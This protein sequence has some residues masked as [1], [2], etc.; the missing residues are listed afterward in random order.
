MAKKFKLVSHV[1]E[2]DIQAV[3]LDYLASL[4]GAKFWTNKTTGT[5]DPKFGG[6][7]KLNGRHNA[8]GSPD[9][10]GTIDGKFIGI[11]VKKPSGIVSPEQQDFI[12]ALNRVGAIAFVARSLDDVICVLRKYGYVP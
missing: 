8:R 12:N 4:P 9:I 7:R 10:L 3:I 2:S 6:F 11:E 5:Y 1:K